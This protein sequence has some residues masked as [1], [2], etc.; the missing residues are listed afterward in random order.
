MKNRLPG[1]HRFGFTL[2]ELLVVIGIIALL[3]SILLPALG[4]AR[5]QA[6]LVQCM[7][8]EKQIGQAILQYSI[9]N[10]GA[11]V[12][13]CIYASPSGN[14]DC[15]GALLIYLKYLPDP[16]I[17]FSM[18]PQANTASV[19]VCPAVRDI[20]A[21]VNNFSSTAI[22]GFERDQSVVLQPGGGGVAQLVVEY[23][24]GLNG[25]C[26]GTSELSPLVPGN[27]DW[28]DV[29]STSIT[30]TGAA[31]YYPPIKKVSQFK[32]SSDTVIVYDGIVWNQMNYGS[33]PPGLTRISGGRH[34]N[35]FNP[36]QPYDTGVC[37]V[38]FMDWHVATVPRKQ[39]PTMNLTWNGAPATADLEFTGTR[40]QMRPGSQILW[41]T[42]QQP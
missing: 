11:V 25:C 7:S 30:L 33:N 17:T 36:A 20:L 3:I 29:P 12:P 34:G 32:Q 4:K 5:R 24:Y 10:N 31:S 22:D 13:C 9:A 1:S 15:W 35:N 41:S 8:N 23:G 38:L 26:N 16:H 19:L 27:H 2:V 37:N 6:V 42:D 21:D 14:R 18:A 39:L 40:S 28:L